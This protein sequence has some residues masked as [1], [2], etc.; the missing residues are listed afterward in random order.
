[1]TGGTEL[2]KRVFVREFFIPAI[3]SNIMWD[4]TFYYA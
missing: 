1:M 4:I 3:A 2:L